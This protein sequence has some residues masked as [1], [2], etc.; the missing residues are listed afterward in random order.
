M[1]QQGTL[2]GGNH[3]GDRVSDPIGSG[4]VLG[5]SLAFFV[6]GCALLVIGGGSFGALHAFAAFVVLAVVAA[7]NQLLPVLTHAPVSRPQAVI[8]V[9]AGFFV[10]FAFL[11]AGFYGAP[12]FGIAALVLALTSLVWVLWNLWRLWAGHAEVQTRALMACAV[13]A[14]ALAVGIGTTMAGT[15]AGRFTAPIGQLGPIHAVL[16]IAGFASLLIVAVSYRF[17]PMFAVAHAKAY[18]RGIAQWVAV[19]SIIAVTGFLHSP[20][21]LRLGLLAL[22]ASGVT[23]GISH[24][25]TLHTRLR[26]R[27]DVSLRYATVAWG[28]GIAA[29]IVAIAATWQ[30]ELQTATVILAVLGWISITIL[31]YS[32]KVA[33]FLAWQTARA[34]RP[35]AQIPPLSTAVHL[36]LAYLALTLLAVGTIV[37]A[38]S[39]FVWPDVARVGYDIYAAGGAGAVVALG[40]LT[41]LYVTGKGT[42]GSALPATG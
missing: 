39:A 19:A 3:L 23:M 35:T 41:A 30:N 13:I 34:R 40:K 12:T 42:D 25:R 1:K 11:I 14:F 38:A 27:L 9:A 18:G 10:G 17:V 8:G 36:P 4:W 26:K 37:S 20:V 21:G 31:G 24:L 32:F 15:L 2:V 28:L 5:G 22:L 7:L 6:T 16:A 29:T 33:G